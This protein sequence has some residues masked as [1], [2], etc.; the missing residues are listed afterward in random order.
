[1]LAAEHVISDQ[2]KYYDH[3]PV[4]FSLCQIVSNSLLVSSQEGQSMVLSPEQLVILE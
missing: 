1:M 3:N 4:S 2:P